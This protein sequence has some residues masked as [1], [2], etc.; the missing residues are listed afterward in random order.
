MTEIEKIYSTRNAEIVANFDCERAIVTFQEAAGLLRISRPTL[1][2]LLKRGVI[3]ARKVG[4]C[5]RFHRDA[6]LA[7][8]ASGDSRVSRSRSKYER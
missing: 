8:V 5:W 4:R 7:W 2:E 6:L 3:P 1:L